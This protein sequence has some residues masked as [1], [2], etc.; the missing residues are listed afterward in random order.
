MACLVNCSNPV[1][2]LGIVDALHAI[3]AYA[4]EEV[5]EQFTQ[6]IP[7]TTIISFNLIASMYGYEQSRA[8]GVI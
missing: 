3:A 4:M 1:R 6:T 5:R 2:A 8:Y 7:N